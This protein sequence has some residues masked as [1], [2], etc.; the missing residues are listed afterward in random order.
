MTLSRQPQYYTYLVQSGDSLSGILEKLY[1]IPPQN[2]AR[3]EAALSHIMAL[4]PKIKN[5]NLIHPGQQIRLSALSLADMDK[6]CKVPQKTAPVEAVA[7]P[8]TPMP[9]TADERDA[10][11]AMAWF[12]HN[13][14]WLTAPGSVALGAGGNLFGPANNAMISQIEQLYNS[15]KAGQ[16]T[17]GQYSYR[18]SQLLKEFARRVGPVEKLLFGGKTTPETIRI[19]RAGGVPATANITRHSAR[20]NNLAKLAKG[21]GVVLTGVGLYSGCVQISK[22]DSQQEKNEIFVETL[23]SAAVGGVAGTVIT[24]ALVSN[25]VGWGVSL[26]LAVGTT[27]VAYGSGKLGRYVYNK[28]GSKVD[29]VGMTKVDELCQ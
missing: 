17:K 27:A 16:L 13:S 4:N 11:W 9:I 15:Y 26:I 18:R 14:Q 20:L 25:P 12:E 22:A 5:R 7:L 21:G 2:T 28:S 10:Y 19:A 8:Q 24:F 29:M 23:G 3:R 6:L 1:A